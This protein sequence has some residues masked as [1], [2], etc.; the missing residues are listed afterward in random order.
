MLQNYLR[1]ILE[2]LDYTA[3]SQS[4]GNCKVQVNITCLDRI[5]A[6]YKCVDKDNLKDVIYVDF[7]NF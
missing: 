1:K 2:Q 5:W 6:D 4:Y 3:S 7:K